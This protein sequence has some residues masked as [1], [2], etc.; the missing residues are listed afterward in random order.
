VRRS[1][2]D[3]GLL[4]VVVVWAFSPTLFKYVLA[5]LQPLAFVFARFLLLSLFAVAVL[6]WRGLRGG[7]AWRIARADVPALIASG[8]CGYGIYQLLY[9]VGLAHTSV[10]ASALLASTVPLWSLVLVAALRTE[11]VHPMQW[12]GVAVSL[13]GAGWFLLVAHGAGQEI[14]PGHV[15]TASDQLLGDLLTLGAAALFAGYGV[16]NR[17]LA[18]R[19]SPPEL[20]CYTLLVGTIALAPFGVP[21]LLAQSWTHLTWRTWVIL[22]YSVIF[23]IYLTY[24]IWNWAIGQRGV[25]Y[26]TVYSYLVPVLGGLIAFVVLGEALSL[27]QYVGGAV[28]L[29]GMLLARLGIR[30][31]GR[32]PAPREETGA[33]ALPVAPTSSGALRRPPSL[34][35][36]GH[37]GG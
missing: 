6:T 9:M 30:L 12:L 13:V 16:V 5:E 29:G 20:M 36:R 21:A 2:T 22:P 4:F 14:A 24:S 35:P 37:G 11:R 1:T 17:Q 28:I 8:L 31:A 23:P 7:R 19:Y 33:A 18:R 15:L 32:R 26:V 34:A 10:F 25:G 27:G 3:L